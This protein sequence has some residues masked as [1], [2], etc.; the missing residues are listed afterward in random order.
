MGA[1]IVGA[2]ITAAS[3]RAAFSAESAA[4]GRFII[5]PLPEGVYALTATARGYA[6]LSGQVV[7]VVAAVRRMS[8]SRCRPHRP[9]A[10][11]R[12]AA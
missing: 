12:W 1:P 9:P 8:P 6:R 10:W 4:D 7:S 5:G 3:T 2:H 11:R